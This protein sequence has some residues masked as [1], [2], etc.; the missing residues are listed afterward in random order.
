[1]HT[2]ST[3][4]LISGISSS[5]KTSTATA[6]Q[7]TLAVQN[8]PFVHLPIHTFVSLLPTK[9][10]N[11]SNPDVN[12]PIAQ[13][14]EGIVFKRVDDDKGVSIELGPVGIRLLQAYMPIVAIIASYGSH[15]IIDGVFNTS[16][17][18][19]AAKHFA[20]Y[21]VY[22]IGIRC[23]LS[24]VEERERSRG[25]IGGIIGLARGYTQTSD[26]HTHNHYDLL[27]DTSTVTAEQ[28]AQEII[29]Y[30]ERVDEPQALKKFREQS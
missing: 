25:A 19:E 14:P 10:F 2:Q 22:C 7:R 5:G 24:I 30:M 23:P 1:M 3:I 28:A 29:E 8:K 21:R 13:N 12:K 9:W 17:L 11:W 4:I 18:H 20:N 26:A 27:V 6:L 15:I 16:Y